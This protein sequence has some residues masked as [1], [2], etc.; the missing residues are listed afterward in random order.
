V[1]YTLFCNFPAAGVCTDGNATIP[2]FTSAIVEVHSAGAG[3]PF[4]APALV[5]GTLQQTQFSHMV[6]DG[7]GR[8]HVFFDDF[9]QAPT[10]NMWESTLIAGVWVVSK[11]PTVSFIYNGLTNLNWAFRDAGAEAPG[12]GIHGATAYCAFSANQVGTGKAE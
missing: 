6:I 3:L 5:S 4:S 1:Y 10:V 12:C 11:A 7:S 9:T 8:P 2:P